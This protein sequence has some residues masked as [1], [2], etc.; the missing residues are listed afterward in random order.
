VFVYAHPLS[1]RLGPLDAIGGWEGDGLGSALA[2]LPDLD[3]DGG[4]EVAVG[5]YGHSSDSLREAG[6]VL[7]LPGSVLP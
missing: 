3:G 6:A 2:P 7:L 5:A 1:G 4:A